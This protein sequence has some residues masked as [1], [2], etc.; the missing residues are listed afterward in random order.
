MKEDKL[1]K[2]FREKLGNPKNKQLVILS[3]NIKKIPKG[4]LETFERNF[5]KALQ[6]KLSMKLQDKFKKFSGESPG[7][8]SVE[9]LQ[10][11]GQTVGNLS[12]KAIKRNP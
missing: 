2:K 12:R 3:G 7:R 5:R 9:F 4:T 10:N 8:T 11:P 6:K 1:R